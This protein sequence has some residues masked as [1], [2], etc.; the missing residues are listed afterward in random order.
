MMLALTANVTPAQAGACSS[1]K[2]ALHFEL[3][4]IPA[5]AGMTEFEEPLHV[6]ATAP[7]SSSWPRRA[8]LA[9]R[10]AKRAGGHP[11]QVLTGPAPTYGTVAEVEPIA[12]IHNARR[13]VVGGRLRGHDGMRGE[14]TRGLR[15]H[16]GYDLEFAR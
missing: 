5:S 6:L 7:F 4:R 3:G 11:R 13:V 9:Q 12:P 16:D 1:F 2:S 14:I 15:G 8:A 10:R